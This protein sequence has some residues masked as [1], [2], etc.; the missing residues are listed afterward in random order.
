[1]YNPGEDNKGLA[2]LI[3]AK[4]RNGETGIVELVFLGDTTSFRNLDRHGPPAT[5]F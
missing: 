3:I 1:V 5:P 4:H 2:E